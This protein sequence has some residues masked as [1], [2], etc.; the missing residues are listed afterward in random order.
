[1]RRAN[2]KIVYACAGSL[3]VM[4]V[5]S[6]SSEAVPVP[7]ALDP[8]IRSVIYDPAQVYR[9]QGYVGFSIEL[10]F[11]ADERFEGQGGGDLDAIAIAAHTN[12]VILKPRAQQVLT[13]LV[14][15]TDR[16]AYRFDYTVGAHVPDRAT[17]E[18]VYT[19]RFEY[20]ASVRADEKARANAQAVERSLADDATT[21]VK[22]WNYWFCGNRAVRPIAAFDDGVHTHLSF[23]HRAELPAVFVL[24]DDGS[25]A[26]L[27]LNLEQ[28]ELVIHRVARRFIVRRGRSTGCIVNRSFNGGGE[29]LDSGTVTPAV[30]RE[31]WP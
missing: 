29:R 5:Q 4:L 25:E 12:H 7:G 26:L 3:L 18:I 15:Y 24:N 8:R 28:G 21:R 2:F 19:V 14:L 22:N 13:N 17:D 23:G 9:L 11:E 10:E 6:A 1:M 27:N 31:R 16:R 30:V 20:P